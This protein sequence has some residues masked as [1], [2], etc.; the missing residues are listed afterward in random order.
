MGVIGAIIG[1]AATVGSAAIAARSGEKTQAANAAAQS[2]LNQET[3]DFNR[4]EAQKARD[5]SAA[6]AAIDRSFNSA[7][8]A[9]AQQFNAA[10]SQKLLN[11]N[12]QESA[13]ARSFEERMS[14]TAHQ[15]E[16]ADL[17]AAGLNP[18]LSGT[19]GSGASTPVAPILS[20]SSAS[21]SPVSHSTPGGVAAALSGMKAYERK[22]I[23]S[24]F[25]HSAREA[26]RLAIDY[27]RAR[28]ADK[29]ADAAHKNAD[30]AMKNAE[31]NAKGQA[32]QESKIKAEIE[33]INNSISIALEDLD[34]R[35]ELKNASV[36]EKH[37]MIDKLMSDIDVNREQAAK[38]GIEKEELERRIRYGTFLSSYLPLEAREVVGNHMIDFVRENKGAIDFFM[39]NMNGKYELSSDEKAKQLTDKVLNWCIKKGFITNKLGK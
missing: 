26:V 14:S 28:V 32:A 12:S 11:Y 6:Q 38:I 8:Q 35:K 36:D 10:Q 5:W 23:M 25:A 9:Q 30:A 34:I 7:Q 15:R 19:G 31:T 22:N 1:A 37:A 16:V 3:M 29:E 24:E 33:S 17:R 20:G 27:E 21:I 2:E 13:I 4:V 18:I 39:D